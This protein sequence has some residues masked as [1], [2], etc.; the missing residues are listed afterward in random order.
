MHKENNNINLREKWERRK[1]MMEKTNK[2]LS[3]KEYGEEGSD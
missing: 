3:N 2:K 1:K